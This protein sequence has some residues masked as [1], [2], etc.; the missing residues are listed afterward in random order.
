MQVK[1]APARIGL[2][3]LFGVG[4]FGNEG[5]LEAML[6][7]LRSARP[8]SEL[9]CICSDPAR[10][11]QE[12]GIQARPMRCPSPTSAI[13]RALDRVLLRLPRVLHLALQTL[14]EART[15]D[16]LIIPG[17]GIL[18]DFGERP[19]ATPLS[20]C[21]WCVTARLCGAK[22]AFVSIGAG[23]I[24][25]TTNLRLMK[26]A[27]R[28]AH[29]RSYRD[30]VS[31]DFMR[32]IGLDT[33][34]D[35]IY[36]DIAFTLPEPQQRPGKAPD[37]PLT[38]GLG[39][40]AYYG[41]QADPHRG[42]AIYECYVGKL[43]RFTNWLLRTGHRVRLLTGQ[44][45][46]QRAV[47]DLLALVAAGNPSAGDRI[48]AE[49]AASLHDLMRQLLDT[50]VVVATRFHNV[51]C[52]LKLGK[53]TISLGYADK[54]DALLMEVGLGDFCQHVEQ[55]NVDLLIRQFTRL[56]AGRKAYE[57]RIRCTTARIQKQLAQQDRLLSEQLLP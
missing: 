50:E 18:D 26:L 19:W 20:L 34:R 57:A 24:N 55:I 22:V 14:H 40:M 32:G 25:H 39:V 5:S 7:F 51:V 23:P 10:V 30:T 52:A 28:M 45:S 8:Q 38:V 1:R 53:P 48:V 6:R 47:D 33:F 3:G 13:F 36:P 49:P 37:R 43:A 16:A 4:N 54:N 44:A 46:D 29:Y 12:H 41:W 56:L 27:A 17:T 42:K 11:Q 2:F 9:V 21:L 31:R 35:P 15:V